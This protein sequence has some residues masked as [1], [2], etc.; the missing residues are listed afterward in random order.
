MNQI[1]YKE[2]KINRKIKKIFLLQFYI[3][4]IFIIVLF[5]Y[6]LNIIKI[7]EENKKI[8]YIINTNAKMNSIF[9]STNNNVY[10]ARIIIEKINLEY[11][12]Y[13]E[14]SEELLKLLPC[15]Y[16]GPELGQE[17]NIIILGHNY[18]DGNF[19]TN[20]KDLEFDN[21]IKLVS[22]DNKIYKYKVYEKIEVEAENLK[23]NISIKE[24]GKFLT[25]CTCTEF[26]NKRLIIRAKLD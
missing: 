23:K 26:K 1:L 7:K 13:K 4:I 21:I 20:L 8:S 15:K 3:S 2:E 18:L 9:S 24:K 12:V 11:F 14:C 22:L 6:W 16:E 17:G 10:F 25:L 5:L 19:F